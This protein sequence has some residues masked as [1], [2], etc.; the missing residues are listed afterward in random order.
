MFS[1]LRADL[2]ANRGNTKGLL[3]VALYRICRG[4]L[5]L[6]RIVSLFL[7]PC[8]VFYKILTSYVMGIDLPL[9]VKAG[10]G[11]RIYHGFGLVV[12]PS[13]VIG[14]N[15][16]LRHGVTIG[17]RATDG[18]N[19]P[20]IHDHVDFGCGCSIL[21]DIVIGCGVTIGANAVVL[22]SLPPYSVAVGIPAKVVGIKS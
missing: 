18:N 13:V 14:S 17:E 19:V 5:A 1:E 22:S 20:S 9:A 16:I 6:P 8:R 2:V 12:H 15:C 21:G 7:L 11:L 4:T 10:P 3:V